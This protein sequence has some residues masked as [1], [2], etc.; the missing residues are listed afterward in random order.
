MVCSRSNAQTEKSSLLKTAP[1][2]KALTAR[3]EHKVRSSSPYRDTLLS[4]LL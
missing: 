4:S 1:L 3:Q 2:L